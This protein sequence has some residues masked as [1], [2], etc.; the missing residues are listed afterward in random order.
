M[1]QRQPCHTC[2]YSP[3]ATRFPPCFLVFLAG[4]GQC[5][6]LICG[7]IRYPPA[8]TKKQRMR[9]EC[10]PM[11]RILPNYSAHDQGELFSAL[12]HDLIVLKQWLDANRLS[13]NVVK[14]KCMFTWTRHKITLLP[15]QP[16]IGLDGYQIE[17]V[18]T[19]KIIIMIV[20][21]IM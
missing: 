15:D 9:H 6:P 20:I 1:W 3:E 14:T 2:M 16:G 13:L 12:S 4:D 8:D 11:I 17:R 21:K 18:T 7:T 10:T 5:S 19:Y